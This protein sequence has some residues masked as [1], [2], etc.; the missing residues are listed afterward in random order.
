MS[1][2]DKATV[3]VTGSDGFVGRHLVPYLARQGYRVIAASRTPAQFEDPE[4]TGA[5]LP[6]LSPAVRLATPAA[7]NAMR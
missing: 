6:D 3:L 4:I 7:D 1:V 5:A 2:N